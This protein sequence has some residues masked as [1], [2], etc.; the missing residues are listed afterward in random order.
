LQ[1]KNYKRPKS[2]SG[3]CS[4]NTKGLENA[5]KYIKEY[6]KFWNEKIDNME[7]FLKEEE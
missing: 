6:T 1:P 4:F 7:I 2:T 3:P 5:S